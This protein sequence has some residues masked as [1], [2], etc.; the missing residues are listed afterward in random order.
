M[1]IINTNLLE[2]NFMT[3]DLFYLENKREYGMLP[4][5]YCCN[6]F[7]WNIYFNEFFIN[8]SSSGKGKSPAAENQKWGGKQKQNS[9][10]WGVGVNEIVN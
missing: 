8:P 10:E 7:N 2:H 6:K 5:N 9:N 4:T 3:L 1:L